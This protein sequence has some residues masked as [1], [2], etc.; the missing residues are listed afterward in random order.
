MAARTAS[1]N[2][3]IEPGLKRAAERILANLG[4]TTSTAVT[5]FYRQVTLRGGLPFDVCLPNRETI[6]ALEEAERGGGKVYHVGSG[7]EL[8][9]AILNDDDE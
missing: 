6:A 1:V 4:M 9:E 8:T 3:R 5:M 2:A 7:R